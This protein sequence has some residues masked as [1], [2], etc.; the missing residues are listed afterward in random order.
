[1]IIY[2]MV[3]LIHWIIRKRKKTSSVD[4][5]PATGLLAFIGLSVTINIIILFGRF[6]L[7]PFQKIATLHIHLWLNMLLPI[8]AL[9]CGYFMLKQRKEKTRLQNI[10]RISLLLI[11]CLF[12]M[13]LYYFHLFW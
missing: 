10:A 12:T 5:F 13:F 6:M 3:A 7:D 1:F 2:T 8:S 11:S 9:V 4:M